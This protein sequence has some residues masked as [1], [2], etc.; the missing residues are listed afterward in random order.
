MKIVY[1]LVASGICFFSSVAYSADHQ[2]S[3]A[4]EGKVL[5]VKGQ[6][7]VLKLGSDAWAA[8]A[9]D[10]VL[11]EGD[12]VKTGA[13]AEVVI[14]TT[15]KAKTA[16]LLLRADSEFRFQTL[17]HNADKDSALLDLTAGSMVVRADEPG[18]SNAIFQVKTP[19]SL[20]TAQG[21]V[22]EVKVSQ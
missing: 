17:R 5:S 21:A 13:V 18:S 6:A 16:E 11:S 2:V 1:C 10:A 8:L 4:S 7:E 9:V 3:D 14:E 22:F 19:T 20:M 12:A 15:G